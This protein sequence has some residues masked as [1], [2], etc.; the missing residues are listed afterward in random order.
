[1]RLSLQGAFSI[2]MGYG[3]DNINEELNLNNVLNKVSEVVLWRYYLGHDFEMGRVFNAKYREEKNP[4]MAL[5]Y[6]PKGRIRF[7]DFGNG[8][9]GDI[10]NY[11]G[12]PETFGLDFLDALRKVNRD[13]S[14]GL[15]RDVPSKGLTK[16]AQKQLVKFEKG[17]VKERKNTPRFEIDARPY[18]RL[19]LDYWEKYG[20]TIETLR[21][22]KVYCVQNLRVNGYGVYTYDQDYPCYAYHFPETDHLKCYYPL[23]NPKGP[24]FAGNVNNLQDIQGY[25]QC[26]VKKRRGDEVLI[27]TKSMKDVMVLHQMGYDA[28]AI[29]GEEHYFAEDFI[30]HIKKYYSTI[31]S[32]Y[33]PDKAGI[34]GARSLWKAHNIMPFFIP[35]EYR[36]EDVKDISDIQLVYGK[37]KSEDVMKNISLSAKKLRHEKHYSP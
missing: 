25:Y 31:I 5:V 8:R 1:M 27:L 17:F 32:L 35:K 3:F 28:M 36:G 21:L 4:S 15:G 30:R 37:E 9:S 10:F 2:F 6:T 16:T 12:M 34:L 33:D 29:N 19:D 7:K 14:L 18:S 22:Y 23:G 11:L 24:R 26:N 13:F 20:I